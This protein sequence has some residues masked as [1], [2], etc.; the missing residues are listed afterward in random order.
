M[1]LSI[2]LPTYNER[3]NIQPLIESILREVGSDRQIEI[4]V[5]DDDSPD[6]TWKVVEKLGKERPQIRLIRRVKERGLSTALQTGISAAR[7]KVIVWM[8]CDFSH[9]PLLIPR[10]IEGVRCFDVVVASRF[11]KGG[12]SEYTFLRTLA[13]LMVSYFARLILNPSVKDYTS[14]FVACRR[15]VFEKVTL[16][17]HHGEYFIGFIYRCLKAGFRIE[18]IPYT[19]VSRRLGESKTAPTLRSLLRQGFSYGIEIIRLRLFG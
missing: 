14:G 15:E 17:G 8:D 1:D 13:S 4:I 7:G 12:K 3:E 16:T 6:G 9:P 2:I 10:L 18:E 11:V 5:V 19:C